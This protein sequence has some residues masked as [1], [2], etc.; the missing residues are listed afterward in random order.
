ME[1]TR[2]FV[3]LFDSFTFVSNA[4]QS[5]Q[6]RRTINTNPFAFQISRGLIHIE[7][8]HFDENNM[9]RT[10]CFIFFSQSFGWCLVELVGTIVLFFVCTNSQKSK[11]IAERCRRQKKKT[12][13][14]SQH[15]ERNR[16]RFYLYIF[17]ENRFAMETKRRMQKLHHSIYR[18]HTA[19]KIRS[20]RDRSP[21]FWQI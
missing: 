1:S 6:S 8:Y 14:G 21:T 7:R 3:L 13:K 5:N 12:Q 11:W 15:L 16:C 18:M 4:R 20:P 19:K 10:C 9:H 2:N 17:A